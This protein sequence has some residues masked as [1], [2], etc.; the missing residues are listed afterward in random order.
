MERGQRVW[1]DKLY[2]RWDRSPIEM[3][4]FFRLKLRAQLERFKDRKIVLATHVVPHPHFTV[5]TPHPV[6]DYFNAFLGSRSYGDLIREFEKLGAVRRLR[7]RSLSGRL[8]GCAP[9][10]G[11]LQVKRRGR[12]K[13]KAPRRARIA[14]SGC[15]AAAPQ[16]PLGSCLGADVKPPRRCDG[17][18]S[19][20]K[21]GQMSFLLLMSMLY[22]I[23]FAVTQC[24]SRRGSAW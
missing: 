20:K 14:H 10:D 6:W 5:A 1:K 11:W 7:P 4:R 19:H 8:L 3:S 2:A 23:S 15:A 12:R 21:I 18:Y 16:T 13:P 17:L 9:S 22:Y 24:I